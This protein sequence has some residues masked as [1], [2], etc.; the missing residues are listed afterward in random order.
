MIWQVIVFTVFYIPL[1]SNAGGFHAIQKLAGLALRE[2]SSGKTKGRTIISKRGRPLLRKLL[3]QAAL[4]LVAKN[5]EFAAEL[6]HYCTTREKNPLKKKQSIIAI[7]CKLIRILFVVLKN[8]VDYNPSKMRNDI[9]RNNTKIERLI[10][11]E[12]YV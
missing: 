6:H 3:F 1:R 5:E 2:S 11:S 8:N 12:R 9:K 4:P 10:E 7:C